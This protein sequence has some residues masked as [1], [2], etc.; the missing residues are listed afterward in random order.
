MQSG[1][2]MGAGRGDKAHMNDR[3]RNSGLAAPAPMQRVLSK[4]RQSGR[5]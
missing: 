1:K 2:P 5:T 3:C 4:V